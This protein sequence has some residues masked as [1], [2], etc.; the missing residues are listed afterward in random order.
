MKKTIKYIIITLIII[1]AT[2]FITYL[3]LYREAK[4]QSEQK[5]SSIISPSYDYIEWDAIET[6]NKL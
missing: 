6:L 5:V 2:G 3:S 4:S 1:L